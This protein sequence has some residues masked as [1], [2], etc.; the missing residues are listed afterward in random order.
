[1]NTV[2]ENEHLIPGNIGHFFVLLSFVASI[3]GTLAYIFAAQSKLIFNEMSWKKIGRTAF[4]IHAFSVFAV[5]ST[6]FYLIFNHYFSNTIMCI[7]I[8]AGPYLLNIY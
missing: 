2:F 6:L 3:M 4:F 7:H 1:M 5:F 8:P